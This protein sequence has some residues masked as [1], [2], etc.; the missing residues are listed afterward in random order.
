MIYRV[1]SL[2]TFSSGA[3]KSNIGHVEGA[4]GLASV[5]KTLLILEKGLIPPNAN[6]ERI[7][8]KIDEE[9]LKIKVLSS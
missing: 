7:N 5:I 4:S 1:L 3:V 2:L 9:A 8:P 6:F